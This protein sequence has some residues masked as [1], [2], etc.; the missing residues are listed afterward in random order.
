M[1]MRTVNLRKQEACNGCMPFEGGF[2]TW[3][4]EWKL[5]RR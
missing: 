3:K 5:W 2:G 1:V 4:K